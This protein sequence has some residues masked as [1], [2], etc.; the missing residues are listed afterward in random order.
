M[1][2]YT[3]RYLIKKTNRIISKTYYMV[4]KGMRDTAYGRA[5]IG[6]CNSVKYRKIE[7]F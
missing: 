7:T 4:N 3:E 6:W 1:R 5:A 2:A